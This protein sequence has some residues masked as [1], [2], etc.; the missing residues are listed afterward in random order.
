M[1]AARSAIAVALVASAPSAASAQ[2]VPAPG[3]MVWQQGVNQS[4][5]WKRLGCPRDYES[6]AE[7]EAMISRGECENA[8]SAAE[9][10]STDRDR[11]PHAP[12]A[13]SHVA[14]GSGADSEGLRGA[15]AG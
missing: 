5:E 8:P 10:P 14:P 12:S 6:D 1:R 15:L 11:A 7:K 13:D 2:V 9:P 3:Y 4:A